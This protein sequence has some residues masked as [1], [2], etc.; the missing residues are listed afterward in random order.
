MYMLYVLLNAIYKLYIILFQFLE[1]T[2]SHSSPF[3]I[4]SHNCFYSILQILYILPQEL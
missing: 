2:H 4:S 3:K 1:I